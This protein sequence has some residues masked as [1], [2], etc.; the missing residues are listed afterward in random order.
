M[1]N[2][3]WIHI[4]FTWNNLIFQLQQIMKKILA[5]W[6]IPTMNLHCHFLRKP[7]LLKSHYYSTWKVITFFLL[8]F[9]SLGERFT[10]YILNCIVI[11]IKVKVACVFNTFFLY[12]IVL[13]ISNHHI[14][15]I[16][17]SHLI[18]SLIFY[19]I[20]SCRKE[21]NAMIMVRNQINFS[22]KFFILK[23]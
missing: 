13:K 14:T 16:K 18:V 11:V 20:M 15:K 4:W 10:Y 8:L 17:R 23:N 12:I 1:L 9:F 22:S 19:Q 21:L 2:K 5:F 3:S 6:K 7:F